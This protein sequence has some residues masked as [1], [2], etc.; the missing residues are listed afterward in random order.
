MIGLAC[1]LPGCCS[2]LPS[3]LLCVIQ[4]LRQIP[5]E[6]GGGKEGRRHGLEREQVLE[7]N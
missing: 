6:V 7:H 4:A 2:L 5:E 1:D 3:T